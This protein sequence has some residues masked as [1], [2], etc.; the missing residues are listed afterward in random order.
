MK[1]H[2]F[3]TGIAVLALITPLSACSHKQEAPGIN[4]T[5]AKSDTRV[6]TQALVSRN[7]KRN[8]YIKNYRI[9]NTVKTGKFKR[10]THYT[11]GNTPLMLKA[12]VNN[13]KPS[14]Y[15][16][17]GTIYLSAK[18]AIG[19]T[20][21]IKQDNPAKAHSLISNATKNVNQ[22]LN[23]LANPVLAGIAKS[24]KT[25]DGYKIDIPDNKENRNKI[26]SQ[27]VSNKK[28]GVKLVHYEIH[29]KLDKKF[30][31]V[32][33]VQDMTYANKNKN[34]SQTIII[35]QIN[36]HNDLTMPKSITKKAIDQK[37]VKI[38]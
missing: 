21:W 8:N 7:L 18:N 23:T 14:M 28:K 20:V 9:S 17:D 1:H 36:Q 30:N 33:Y 5:V 37:K 13:D 31:T 25:L 16:Q 19:N 24:E 29:I 32:K 4:K 15:T 38:R 3:I 27:Y 10:T 6:N 26:K 12:S 34:E 11:L 35:D 22:Y 2:K